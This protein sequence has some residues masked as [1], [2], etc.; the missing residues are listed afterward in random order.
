[1]S[2]CYFYVIASEERCNLVLDNKL[3]R[4]YAPCPQCPARKASLNDAGGLAMTFNII[5]S[6]AF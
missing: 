5:L 1:M 3:L 2:L 6:L 4:R